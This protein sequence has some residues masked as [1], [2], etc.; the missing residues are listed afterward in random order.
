MIRSTG[1]SYMNVSVNLNFKWLNFYVN[2]F[3]Y[4]EAY[5]RFEGGL[6]RLWT[7]PIILFSLQGIWNSEKLNDLL[8]NSGCKYNGKVRMKPNSLYSVIRIFYCGKG[9]AFALHNHFKSWFLPDYP[10]F[11]LSVQALKL[12][13]ALSSSS[14]L[15]SSGSINL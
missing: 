3:W 4:L 9:L 7:S 6:K 14:S 5:V 12:V 8:I 1:S 2:F 11:C 13:D 10:P 15:C